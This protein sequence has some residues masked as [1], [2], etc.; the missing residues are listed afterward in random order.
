MT[1]AGA[2]GFSAHRETQGEAESAMASAVEFLEHEAAAIGLHEVGSLLRV[3]LDQLRDRRVQ[4]V[5]S[6][7][8]RARSDAEG[9]P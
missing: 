3:V 8:A 1:K 5:A 7:A 4:R 2:N 9:A 6:E